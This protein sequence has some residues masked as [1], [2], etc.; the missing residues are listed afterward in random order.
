MSALKFFTDLVTVIASCSL[1]ICFFMNVYIINFQLDSILK[2]I[3]E[4]SNLRK[5]TALPGLYGKFMLMAEVTLMVLSP[6]TAAKTHGATAEEINSIPLDFRKKIIILF[7]IE[8]GWL[9]STIL[10]LT[11]MK[12]APLIES[13]IS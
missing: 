1:V 2:K 7:Y 3:S 6:K 9:A 5:R 4:V 12:A 8:A 13:A 11:L 10:S